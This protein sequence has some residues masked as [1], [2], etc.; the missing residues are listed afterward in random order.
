MRAARSSTY[1]E[2][3]WQED[4]GRHDVL[5]S[6]EEVGPDPAPERPFEASCPI[7]ADDCHIVMSMAAGAPMAETCQGHPVGGAPA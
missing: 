7:A 1:S 2:D 5:E 3:P 4:S 6:M